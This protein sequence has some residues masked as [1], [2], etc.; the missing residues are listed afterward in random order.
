MKIRCNKLI[1]FLLFFSPVV[2]AQTECS[3]DPPKNCD[4]PGFT[5][6]SATSG[7]QSF[8]AKFI[9]EQLRLREEKGGDDKR[10]SA[11][12]GT[13][14]TSLD[15]DTVGKAI[16]FDSDRTGVFIGLDYR[17]NDNFW[18]GTSI[19]YARE[20]AQ[21][22]QNLRSQDINEYGLS[23]YSFYDYNEAHVSLLARYAD[24]DYDIEVEEPVFIK[25]MTSGKTDGDRFTL[26]IEGGYNFDLPS[27]LRLGINGFLEYDQITVES[28]QLSGNVGSISFEEDEINRLTS[29][30]GIELSKVTSTTFGV[31]IPSIFFDWRHEF[32]D[33][34]RTINGLVFNDSGT[35][36]E[37]ITSVT[38]EPDRNYFTVGANFMMMFA[39]GFSTYMSYNQD[40]A[41]NNIK[42]WRVNLG[43]RLE[44]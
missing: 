43:A 6:S 36:V 12:L 8:D 1:Y 16:G 4:Q 3:G 17:L 35:L 9:K 25:D 32:E 44:F 39:R 42:Y 22:D 24:Q 19:D 38:L 27:Q 13:D 23:V 15:Q 31:F 28:H 14:F 30:L 26:S 37:P 33:D 21:F 11:I 10:F 34:S 40:I 29:S 18:F 7:Q 41:H 20:D 2:L 5:S